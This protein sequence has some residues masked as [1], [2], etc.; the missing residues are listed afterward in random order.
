MEVKDFW[1]FVWWVEHEK[2]ECGRWTTKQGLTAKEGEQTEQ[3]ASLVGRQP[4]AEP[5]VELVEG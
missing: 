2:Q 3:K 5:L 4:D 1:A